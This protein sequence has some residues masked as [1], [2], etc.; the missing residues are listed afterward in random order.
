MTPETH[1]Y[2]AA[3]RSFCF[4]TT[5]NGEKHCIFNWTTFP[6]VQRSLCLKEVTDDSSSTRVELPN[7]GDNQTRDM[8]ERCMATCGQAARARAKMRSRVRKEALAQETR[9]YYNEFARAKHL[10]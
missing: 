3:A 10:E 4:V 7:G 8:L 6:S 9:G 5:A 1:K 2:A